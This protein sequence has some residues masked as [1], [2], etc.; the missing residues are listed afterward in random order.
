MVPVTAHIVVVHALGALG[1]AAAALEAIRLWE[2][3]AERQGGSRAAVIAKGP[4]A[5]FKA[6]VL[7][8][9]GELEQANELNW[10]A[11]DQ[12]RG[13]GMAE[14]EAHA[15]VDLA[16]GQLRVGQLDS[17]ARY[18]DDAALLQEIPHANC[19]YHE[20]RYR[21]LRA[22][23]ALKGGC[24]EE[25]HASANCLRRHAQE[26]GVRRYADLAFLLEVQ[27]TAALGRP[28]EHDPVEA[29]L[30]RLPEHSGLEAWWVAAEVAA[31][32]RYGSVL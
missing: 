8:G 22:R 6:W 27:A 26:I 32:T 11:R 25:A 5:N 14:A 31:A 15:L 12:A 21:L 23:L 3:D 13:V 17:A 19:W 29:I 24:P 18:L 20:L 28:I 1:K 4:P 2:Q 30:Q 16:D 7:R 10:R 9:L